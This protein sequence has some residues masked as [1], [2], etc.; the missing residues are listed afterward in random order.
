[1][2]ENVYKDAVTAIKEAILRS[3]YRAVSQANKEQLSL[4]YGIGRFVS[5]NSRIGFWGTGAIEQIS[6]R[7]QKEL[8]GLRGFSVANLKKMRYF[9][10]EWMNLINRSP[11]AV[12][13]QNADISLDINRSPL[14]TD[15]GVVNENLLL[16]E[17]RQPSADE[18]NPIEFL[19]IPDIGNALKAVTV[20]KLKK[21]L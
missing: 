12:E 5:E 18:F 17:I 3:Q 1:M 9:Y 7:L 2:T 11:V 10:E 15:L 6:V 13:I 20:F 4:Y 21:L 14:A 16:T 19:K 8:P